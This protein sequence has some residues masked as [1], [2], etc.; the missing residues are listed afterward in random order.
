M[1]SIY[2]IN[3]SD[4]RPISLG[5]AYLY[6]QY[7][8]ITSFLGTNYGQEYV[9]LL[10]KPVIINNQIN[11]HMDYHQPLSRIGDLSTDIQN[12]I[13]TEYW[14]VKNKLDKDIEELEY[15]R[16]IEKKNWGNILKQIFNDENNVILTD[17][18]YWCLL[19]GWKFMNKEENY[20]Q[21][22]FDKKET[23]I[24]EAPPEDANPIA[25][26]KPD[27]EEG[28]IEPVPTNDVANTIKP[29]NKSFWYGLKIG[30]RNFVYRYWGILFFILFCLLMFCLM[31]HCSR[32]ECPEI[33]ELNN[34]LDSLNNEINARCIEV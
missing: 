22:V 33:Y 23:N 16:A 30:L 12:R 9:R 32:E 28:I 1:N 4:Y 14:K 29:Q 6:Q 27:I 21:P 5:D 26:Q 25:I 11:W 17:G 19:W 31:Q 10:A 3:A 20:L 15:S 8:K 34:Q 24:E 7:D 2:L 13:K 18:N